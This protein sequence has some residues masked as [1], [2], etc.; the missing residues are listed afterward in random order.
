M[1]IPELPERTV[2]LAKHPN[3]FTAVALFTFLGLVALA[4][5]LVSIGLHW[6]KDVLVLLMS[7]PPIVVSLDWRAVGFIAASVPLTV[8]VWRTPRGRL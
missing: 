5:W 1:E 6:A 4:I 3:W 7:R 8:Y 2:R